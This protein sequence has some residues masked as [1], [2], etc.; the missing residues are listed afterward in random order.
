MESIRGYPDKLVVFKIPASRF[1]WMRYHDGKPIKRS[2][3]TEDNPLVFAK[4]ARTSVE[5]LERFY[6]SKIEN[7][8][9]RDELHAKKPV[10]RQKPTSTLFMTPPRERDLNEMIAEGREQLPSEIRD[11]PLILKDGHLEL[12]KI[13]K[14]KE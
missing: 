9:H 12:P 5:M 14:P 1:W 13:P 8:K 4:N 10:R 2:T 6:L 3:K 11:V 7:E